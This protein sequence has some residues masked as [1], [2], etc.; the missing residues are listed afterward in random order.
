MEVIALL[1]LV[2]KNLGCRM[3]RAS[4][5]DKTNYSVFGKE[6]K[7]GLPEVSTWYGAEN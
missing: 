5:S 7:A 1:I 2:D 6:V 3:V 4:I